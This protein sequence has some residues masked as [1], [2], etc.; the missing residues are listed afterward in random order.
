[1]SYKI[2][3]KTTA[4]DKGLYILIKGT[5]QYETITIENIFAET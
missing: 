5:I 4:R 1:M 3:L 2:D